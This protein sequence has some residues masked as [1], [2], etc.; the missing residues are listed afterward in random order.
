MVKKKSRAIALVADG[1]GGMTQVVDRR[2]EGGEWPIR[3]D[4]PKQE[5]S[6]WLQYFSVE[7]EKRGFGL[8]SLGQLDRG[9]NSGSITVM[10]ADPATPRLAVV[11]E[12]KRDRPMKVRARSAG[13]PEFPLD[14]ARELLDAATESCRAGKQEQFHKQWQLSY[15]GLPWRGELW[16][17]DSLRLCAS[18]LQYEE[19]LYGPRIILVDWSI[20]AIDWRDAISVFQVR[21][22][23]LSVFLSVVLGHDL[24][25]APKGGHVWTWVADE[26]GHIETDVRNVG[27]W[28]KNRPT[29][30]PVRGATP[31]VPLRSVQRPELTRDHSRGDEDEVRVPHDIIELW[32]AFTKLEGERRRQFLQVGSMWQLANSLSRDHQTAAYTLRVTA[33]EALKPLP[34]EFSYHTIYEVVEALLGQGAA[35]LLRQ[36]WFKPQVVRNAH[37]H[38]GEFRGDEFVQQA[39]QSSFRDP[40]FDQAASELWWIS[41]ASIIEWLCRGG[42]FTMP[43]LKPRRRRSWLRTIRARALVLLSVC[44]GVGFVGGW[45]LRVRKQAAPWKRWQR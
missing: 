4:V 16:L 22:R 26:S 31:A 35:G 10:S 38:R 42:E 9:E 8:N 17:D 44:S 20:P 45:V 40:T 1:A 2:F 32:Q 25:V 6:T 21:L 37:L 11:W 34:P 33:C 41:R 3:F 30:M 15:D 28:E 27:Y 13:Q 43:P 24:Q 12:R 19:A 7:C 39:I 18:S 23:E 5:A 36:P 14:L 29:A